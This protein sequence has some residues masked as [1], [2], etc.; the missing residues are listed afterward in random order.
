M[1]DTLVLVHPFD[2]SAASKLIDQKTYDD[3]SPSLNDI[4]TPP[5][6]NMGR[7]G[8]ITS[9]LNLSSKTNGVYAPKLTLYKRVVDG[10]FKYQLYIEFSAPKML[11]GNN[12]EEMVDTDL[13]DLCF[14]LAMTLHMNGV[15]LQEKV[16]KNCSVKTVHYSKNI[17]FQDGTMP[18]YVT[19]YLN[20]ANLRKTVKEY[21]TTF[22]NDGKARYVHPKHNE[23]LCLYDKKQELRN[24][25]KTERNNWEDESWC[26]FDILD[27]IGKVEVL[28]VELR[29][30]DKKI[31]RSVLDEC[32][33]TYSKELPLQ[34]LCCVDIS[35][36]LLL[37][38][39]NYVVDK[40]PELLQQDSELGDLAELLV[41]VNPRARP[42]QLLKWV[43]F[44][45]LS[46][47]G[48][49]TSKI[50]HELKVSNQQWSYLNRTI[51]S[52]NLPSVRFDPLENVKVQLKKFHAIRLEDI[53]EK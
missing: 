43:G 20:K 51:K 42:G 16:L 8:Y 23:S 53:S 49:S 48:W 17:I 44:C 5:Y 24:A 26:Q 27:S 30:G 13:D 47:E 21:E 12:F 40:I 52:L 14:R 22:A 9:T 3:W 11:F 10:G 32:G 31:I 15:Y 1:V 4:L 46:R 36:K 39:V 7:K 19:D 35:R 6:I 18:R 45:A 33:V 41:A 34:E 37:C 25:K 38:K 28:R 2:I 50:R 29:L